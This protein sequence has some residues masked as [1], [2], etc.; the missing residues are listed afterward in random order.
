MD[1][2]ICAETVGPLTF[3]LRDYALSTSPAQHGFR[4]RYAVVVLDERVSAARLPLPRLYEGNDLGEAKAA[5]ALEVAIARA[6][7]C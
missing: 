7:A 4:H 1:C 2:T 3:K 6:A 5:L